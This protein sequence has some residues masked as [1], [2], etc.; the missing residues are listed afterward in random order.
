MQDA[1]TS[2]PTIETER[3]VLRAPRPSDAGLIAHY[4]GDVRVARMT[5]SIPHPYPREAADAFVRR[6]LECPNGKTTWTIEGHGLSEVLGLLTLTPVG[7]RRCEI[8]FWIAPAF[9]NGGLASEAVT[10]L[11]RRNPLGCEVMFATVFQDN[12]ASA[13]VLTGAGFAYIG[14]AEA[15]CVARGGRV[16]TWTYTRRMT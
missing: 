7:E 16:D 11:L 3:L 10:G 13:R 1:L 6:A 9:W 15:N 14:D 2:I 4:A 5:A 12:P 8:G